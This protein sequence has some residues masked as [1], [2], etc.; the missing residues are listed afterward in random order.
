MMDMIENLE[1]LGIRQVRDI[2]LRFAL[3]SAARLGRAGRDAVRRLTD[4]V[5]LTLPG[6]EGY[7]QPL[8][9]AGEEIF[10]GYG[11]RAV[12]LSSDPAGRTFYIENSG[13][14][15]VRVDT[16]G[17]TRVDGESY[18]ENIPLYAEVF[19]GS[20]AYAR[21]FDYIPTIEPQ[22]KEISFYISVIDMDE[23]R[24]LGRSA[25]R[26]TLTLPTGE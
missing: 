18:G 17:H 14:T 15:A 26:I 6:M 24:L 1:T 23:N 11:V 2:T 4:Y 25:E 8:D 13:K 7:E 21:L 20:A 10:T 16:F 3:D 19:P 9:Q 12:R 22:A 5:T